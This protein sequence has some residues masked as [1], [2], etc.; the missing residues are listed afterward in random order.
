MMIT[1]RKQMSM[2][3]VV[4]LKGLLLPTAVAL[5][6]TACGGGG[7]S[8]SGSSTPIPPVTPPIAYAAVATS[9]P[10]LVYA[11]ADDVAI[12][13]Q[14]NA[15]R[16]GSRSGLLAQ[17]TTLD[18]AAHNHTNFLV[19]NQLVGNDTYLTST[20][21][22]VTGGHYENP[23]LPGYTG[24]L[25]QDRATKVGYTGTVSELV[26]F[27]TA[28]G[29]DCVAAFENTVYHLTQMLSPF[30]DVGID[31]NAGNG[32]G[33]ACA[34]ELG[35]PTTS[36]GQLP[37]AGTLVTFPYAG[38]TGVAPTFYN[39][40]EAPNPAPDLPVAGHA[41]LVSLYTTATPTLA[42]SDI[43]VQTFSI[44]PANG[45]AV[46]ARLLANSGVKLMGGAITVDN[47]IAVP[48]ELV[49]LPIVALTPNTVYN[50][51]FAATVKGA[52]VSQKWSFTTGAAN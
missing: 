3:Q 30:M 34:I 45:T 20:V 13:T 21:D 10:V 42:A 12:A 51:S 9:V 44:T 41:V 40:G 6:L 46:T 36:L 2:N 33:S 28:S 23:S 16:Q 35:V 8:G 32:S 24:Q 5:A 22:G 31:F 43:V 4:T 14:L 7:G 37:A 26:T 11:L 19:S 29:A 1:S 25:P 27:G 50:V 17:S 38:M 18:L 49:L 48:G 47:T 15:S 52:A 39:Q